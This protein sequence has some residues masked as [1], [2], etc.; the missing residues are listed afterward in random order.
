MFIDVS[1]SVAICLNVLVL[2]LHIYVCVSDCAL[3]TDKMMNIL[4]P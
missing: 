2:C 3:D 1:I 4:Q